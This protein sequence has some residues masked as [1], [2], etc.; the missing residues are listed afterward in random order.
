MGFRTVPA[1]HPDEEILNLCIQLLTNESKTGLIDQLVI[2]GKIMEAG[3][4][5][6][7]FVDHGGANFF[8]MPKFLF[9]SLKKAEK[10]V[11]GQVEKLK[12]GEFNDDFFEAVKL[13]MTRQNEQN[14]ENM[15]KRLF[16]LIE[17]FEF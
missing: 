11:K 9:Q 15:E 3:A 13:T 12:L 5:N 7:N 4:F 2:D 17:L 8:F 1:G 10:L 6:M 16:T 14:I